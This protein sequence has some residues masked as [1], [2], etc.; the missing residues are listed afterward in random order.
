MFHPNLV[1]RTTFT[2]IQVHP[3]TLP[4]P[5]MLLK[6]EQFSGLGKEAHMQ[7]AQTS[8]LFG[9]ERGGIGLILIALSVPKTFNLHCIGFIEAGNVKPPGGDSPI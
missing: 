5:T 7:S 1:V 9:G 2:V 6:S 3:L 4:P 8:T